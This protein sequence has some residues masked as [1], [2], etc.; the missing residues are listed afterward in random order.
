MNQNGVPSLP[1]LYCPSTPCTVPPLPVP[2]LHSLHT[3]SGTPYPSS[4]TAVLLILSLLHARRQTEAVCPPTTHKHTAIL[5]T[6]HLHQDTHTHGSTQAT[7][8]IS[9]VNRKLFSK[10]ESIQAHTN[11]CNVFPGDLH[12]ERRTYA[13]TTHLC[14]AFP[15]DLHEEQHTH[16][17]TPL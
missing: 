6:K 15:G 14:N 13:H 16:A 1:S 8:H 5:H 3:T 10:A 7:I 4:W 12:E 2:S 11:L 17:H 9:D